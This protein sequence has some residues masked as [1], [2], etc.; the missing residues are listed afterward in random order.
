MQGHARLWKCRS[1]GGQLWA[2]GV[3]GC[4]GLIKKGLKVIHSLGSP[5]RS[6]TYPSSSCTG[7]IFFMASNSNI[8]SASG[9]QFVIQAAFDN[10]KQ[11]MQQAI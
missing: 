9:N 2:M 1:G 5:D 3:T 10:F 6:K 4:G 7:E 11:S 8:D